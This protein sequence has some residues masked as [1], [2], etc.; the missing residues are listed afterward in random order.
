MYQNDFPSILILSCGNCKLYS[1]T[2]PQYLNNFLSL[3]FHLE[4]LK[5]IILSVQL[6]IRLIVFNIN[7]AIQSSCHTEHANC[8]TTKLSSAIILLSHDN[9]LLLS[10]FLLSFT[11]TSMNVKVTHASLVVAVLMTS[12]HILVHVQLAT[13]ALTVKQVSI[14]ILC[15]LPICQCLFI[16]NAYI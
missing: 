4:F 8:Q 14:R 6:D 9:I 1:N 2:V 15:S 10:Y 5:L 12:T 13:Q 11:Q 3:K 16:N 7:T